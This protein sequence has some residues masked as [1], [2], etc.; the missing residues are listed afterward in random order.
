MTKS[1]RPGGLFKW[2]K[3]TRK[4]VE[5]LGPLHPQTQYPIVVPS[6]LEWSLLRRAI[7]E[8]GADAMLE[9]LRG[10]RLSFQVGKGEFKGLTM[11][12]GSFNGPGTWVFIPDDEDK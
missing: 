6:S 9:S 4:L 11:S 8:A 7:F 5:E 12:F 3:K 10:E 1:W 2:S